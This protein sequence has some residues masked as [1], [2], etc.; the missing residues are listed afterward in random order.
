MSTTI[1]S[2][3]VEMKFD[4]KQFEQNVSTTMSTLE[5][6][7]QSLN[8]SGASKGLENVNNAAKGINLA[9]IGTA[10]ETVGLKFNAMYTI[11]DQALRRIT[12]SAY[13]AGKKIVSA[14]TIDPIKTGFQ[15]Y[16][17]QI[18]SVQTILANT[19]SKGTTLDQVN[20]ALDTLNTY[21]DKTIYNFTQMT[22][23]IGTFT[24]AG[25]DLDTSVNAIQGIANLAA[26]SG[27]NSQQ[28]STAMYQLSQALASGTV[29]LMDWN[30]VVNAGMGGQV[31]Q[32]ALKET[33][34][35]HNVKIDDMIKK[36]GSFRETLKNGWLTAD[37]LT[38]TL[39]HFTMA[40]EE[41]T[42][43]WVKFKKSLTDS[44]YSE[45]QANA[46][47][48]LSNTATDAA[49]KVKTATQL[50]DTLK[51]TAQSGWTQTWEIILG[52]FEEAKEL[53]SGIY[54]T[55]SPMLEATAKARNELIEG[56]LTSN[57][58]KM[59]TKINDAG[60]ATSRFEEQVRKTAEAH[61]IDL[62]KM[63]EDHGSLEKAFRSGAISSKVLMEAV[64][65]LEGS[66][67]DLQSI[68]RDLSKGKTGEDV[69]KL[70][71]ALS[72]LNYDIGSSGV[73]GILGKDTEKAI[74]AF[75][76]AKGLEITGIVDESTIKALEE[77]SGSAKGL[78]LSVAALALNVDKLGGRELLIKS[79]KNVFD[80]VLSVVKPIK[81][82][83]SEI[84]PPATADQVYSIIEAIHNFSE[85]LILGNTAS[86]NLK[87]TFKGIF[88]VLDI[89]KQAIGAVINAIVPLFG[90]L[91]DLG[92][93]VLDITASWG[94]WLVA[95]N[96]TIKKTGFFNKVIE[97][98]YSAFDKVKSFLEPVIEGFNEF[99]DAF[100]EAFGE[101][102][103][104]AEGRLAPLLGLL[105]IIKLTF[106]GIGNIVKKVA[107]YIADAASGIGNVITELM[108]TIATA[109]QEADYDKVF[110][111]IS[112]GIMTAI[113]IGIAK[114]VNGGGDVFSGASDIVDNLKDILE[115]A[116]DALGAFT[117]SL[118]A[119]TLKKIATAI[120]IL[121]GSLLVLS[122]IDSSKLLGS[123]G[124]VTTMFVELMAAMA[125]FGK[126]S[127]GNGIKDMLAMNTVASAMSTLA[128]AILVLS[129]ALK[130]M[131]TM[132]PEE[133]GV[134]LI[135][136]TASLG[137]LIGSVKLLSMIGEKDIDGASKN[138]KKLATSLL[139]LSVALKIMSTMSW[140]EMGVA[141]ISMT[142]GLGAMVAAVKLMPNN[143]DKKITGMIGLATAIVILGAALKIMATMSWEEVGKSLL[144][145]AGSLGIL[146]VAMALM[147][148]SFSGVNA[149]KSVVPILLL[150]AIAMKVMGS[151]SWE[152]IARGLV[153]LAGSLAILAIAM[154]LMEKSITGAFAIEAIAPSL[155]LL[156]IAMK[157]MGSLSWDQV[158]RGLVLLAGAFVIIGVAGAVLGPMAPMI[159]TL[160]GAIAVLGLACLA[161][162]AG[163]A[164]L[165][166][167]L[168]MMNAALAV[169]RVGLVTFIASLVALIPFVAEQIGLGIIKLCET[170]AGGASAICEAATVIIVALVDALIASVPKLVEGALVLIIGVLEALVNH[171]PTLVTYLVQ[172]FVGLLD[173]LADHIP[174]LL[175]SLINVIT[176]LIEGLIENTSQFIEPFITLFGEIFQ[177]VADIVSAAGETITG[178]L[179]GLASTVDSISGTI[180]TA[181]T[182]VSEVFDSVF[183]GISEV[184]TSV[185]DSI[186]SVLDGIAGVIESIGEAALNAGTGFENLA[187]GVKIITDL[188][189][190]DMV[191]SLA[192]VA[193]GIGDIAKHS[194][195][196]TDVSDGMSKLDSSANVAAS[197]FK[198]ASTV[199]KQFIDA[200]KT[201]QVVVK[202]V[203][204]TLVTSCAAAITSKVGLFTTAGKNLG[205]GL[206]IGINAKKSSV[207]W[208]AYALGQKAVEGEKDGQKSHS[209]SKATIQ[210]GKWLGEGLVIGMKQMGDKVYNAGSTLGER[211]TSNISSTISQIADAISTD[212]DA[213]P[214]IRP[215]LDLS[216]VKSGANAISGMLAGGGSLGV[217][218]NVSAISSMMNS[219]G[220]NGTNADVVS[221]ID[222]LN[223]KMDNFGNT[224]YSI[225]GVTYDDGSN[226]AEAV[227]TITR[228]AVRERRV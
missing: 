41:G 61:N 80:A 54:E 38:E 40:A 95:L 110:D 90:G 132:S 48:K 20:S 107:P 62:D 117:D 212:I 137:A 154:K 33:A 64:T 32:D 51:E 44:G 9:P 215:V 221:A 165:G 89:F 100:S 187:N 108:Q 128:K 158:I 188:K 131:S 174:T 222:K 66:L 26:V 46:I 43:E 8:L 75:Q 68:E 130:I 19:E 176:A 97:K 37:I 136:M 198:A 21:A 34:R 214:T 85:K 69:K 173:A 217:Q 47:L 226:I 104:K 30:S 56:A 201:Y 177:G 195:D 7:K 162:G 141:L 202:T 22:R 219:R 16:E 150:L 152:E 159:M 171:L 58:D 49:T 13:N 209:P 14:L 106:T 149:I 206:V 11:A 182:G 94:D 142:V 36:E 161:V 42:E 78:S 186:K 2:R 87:R 180:E 72:N 28:A 200:I 114:F 83:F 102:T 155:V 139:V 208:A 4:N 203:A 45:E 15:E 191:A 178:I 71:E 144:A 88:A 197:S 146:A 93:S 111:T 166:A 79:L 118:K 213:Q 210:A 103:N 124:A 151:M 122:F 25:V 92:G 224:T 160:A 216:N 73:D 183:N 156:A 50:W 27:S 125:I 207:Y 228:A 138:I 123:L 113:G 53:F 52:D 223:K 70:Q 81:E 126:I 119:E 167:G 220:Q 23:N 225:A 5:K 39:S 163:I 29:K 135:S 115:G 76:E 181:L 192:A 10:A 164:L 99:K 18:N 101:F 91:D 24:A 67:V 3:V 63:I 172:L 184:I 140:S 196:I 55:L 35:V 179:D 105:N 145:L 143:A 17:T 121:A 147:S 77:A 204:M 193:S 169:G 120:A 59:L 6:L 157:L 1:D 227:R 189:L 133:M 86:E 218:A 12:D 134:A 127:G 168:L 112:G 31:F 109:I 74:K 129:I 60:I 211:A 148:N 190:A 116:G 57:W 153:T 205:D 82:A 65:N 199:I 84:F 185:G 175:G 194:T 96:E 170:I 98:I